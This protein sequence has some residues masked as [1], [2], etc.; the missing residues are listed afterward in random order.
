MKKCHQNLGFQIYSYFFFT[1][2][3]SQLANTM[4]NGYLH[5]ST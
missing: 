2:K 5:L 3:G 4:L 1:L